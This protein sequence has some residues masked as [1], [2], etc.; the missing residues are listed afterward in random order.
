MKI[1]SDVLINLI[2]KNRKVILATVAVFT[3]LAAF[4]ITRIDTNNDPTK[5][6]PRDLPELVD[7]ENLQ[8]VFLSP[9][10]VLFIAEFDD[11]PLNAKIDYMS[12]WGRS[13]D[14]LDGIDNIMHIGALQVPVAGGM[15]GLTG[16][17]VVSKSS[18]QTESQ[19]R[20]RI[21]ASRE[22]TGMFIS[23]DESA[24]T[25]IMDVDESKNQVQ[26]ISRVDSMYQSISRKAPAR[27]YITGAAMYAY[28][29][30]NAMKRDFAILLP[31][32]LAVVFVLLYAAFRRVLHVSASVLI[33][34]IALLWTF[35]IMGLTSMQFSVVT[36]IIPV[37][38]F[39]IGVATAIHVFRTYARLYHEGITEKTECIKATFGELMNPVFLSAITTF[40]GF[41]SFSM[42]RMMWTRT[43]GIFTSI[44]VIFSLVL[45]VALLPI[46]LYYDSRPPLLRKRAKPGRRFLPKTA[47]L[48][49]KLIF[50]PA[51]WWLGILFV[52]IIGIAGFIRVRVEGNPI[53]MFPPSS[54]IRKSDDLIGKYL[55]GTRF[56]FILL[57]HKE[58]MNTPAQWEQVARISEYAETNPIV[59]GSSS[60]LPLIN[61]VS[62]IL[63]DSSMSQPA[64]TMLL[65]SRGM[66]G[67]KFDSYLRSWITPDRRGVKIALI[68]K[69]VEGTRFIELSRSLKQHIHDNFPDFEVLVA[70]P[71]VLND[72]MTYLLINTQVSSLVFAFI[73]VFA[74]LCL[75]F[76]SV[77]IGA[78]AM[79]PIILSTLSVYSLMGFIGVAI[80]S[81]TIVI[82]N[83][84]VGIGIDY[85]I[86]FTD[87]YLMFRR[88]SANRTEAL[89]MTASV[90]GSAIMFNTFIVGV[91]FL[92]LALSTFPPIRSLGLFVFI[93][94]VTS[95]LYALFFLPIMFKKFGGD[96][97]TGRQADKG[98]L[99]S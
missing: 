15:M 95:S 75:L 31:I 91:G 46:V 73:F 58:P 48:Y 43:F 82:V 85:S 23:S 22:L 50:K 6:L 8:K 88:K 33:I 9:R 66:L 96:R 41:A 51:A 47:D 36:S 83:T 93:S 53:A 29:I 14:S 64:I 62:L 38:L 65:K 49:R 30:D 39:P 70:G 92:V 97:R 5:T 40:A 32:C 35:G 11:M 13:F 80:D 7:Y 87:G 21:D 27:I 68:C 69:N 18:R 34:A 67:K 81:V 25:M 90:K 98:A 71:P 19:I 84:C 99:I 74:V 52:A 2:I 20:E 37:I 76:R 10:T 86:H 45:S 61:K 44:G 78:F 72:A 89:L 77:K 79:V 4:F 26:I 12:L 59:G 28:F 60:L 17:F 16:D 1:S 54:D 55:G 56:L 42:S 57:T 24:L 3:V 63:S 94:M